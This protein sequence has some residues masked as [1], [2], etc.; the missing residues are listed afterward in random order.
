MCRV[1]YGMAKST[2]IDMFSGSARPIQWDRCSPD[3]ELDLDQAVAVLESAIK[4]VRRPDTGQLVTQF[5]INQAIDADTRRAIQNTYRAAMRLGGRPAMCAG[6]PRVFT[7]QEH[8]ALV[9]G[10]VT[11]TDT[12]KAEVCSAG[13]PRPDRALAAKREAGARLAAARRADATAIGRRCQRRHRR[14]R[15]AFPSAIGSTA[16]SRL[17]NLI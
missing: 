3:R 10:G 9:R 15:K 2:D 8:W 12:V 1:P 7:G 14:H 6:A 16:D 17:K 5:Q 4:I 11:A 13:I